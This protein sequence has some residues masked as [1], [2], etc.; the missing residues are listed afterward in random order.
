MS[1]FPQ[2]LAS[3]G[4]PTGPVIEWEE[5]DCLLC[6]RRDPSPLVESADSTPGG[7]GY[8]FA[9]AQCQSCGLCYTSPRP[10][11]CTIGQF[12]PSTYAPHRTPDPQ[13]P[14]PRGGWFGRER[15]S[16]RNPYQP[17]WPAEGR[18]LDFGCGGGAFLERMHRHSW[19]VTGLDVST[20]A[21][22]RVRS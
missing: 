21:V 9:V 12:Y 5:P 14:R 3:A 22:Q 4:A 16:R 15:P 6:N 7:T 20:S 13:R 1:F 11:A 2:D 19:R 18:L 17:S 10:N 8:W